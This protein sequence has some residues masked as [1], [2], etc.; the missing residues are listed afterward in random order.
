MAH[1]GGAGVS[2]FTTYTTIPKPAVCWFVCWHVHRGTCWYAVPRRR[3][4][5][6]RPEF[7][8]CRGRHGSGRG[9]GL[10]ASSPR[11]VSG[12]LQRA[13]VGPVDYGGSVAVRRGSRLSPGFAQTRMRERHEETL[14]TRCVA[15]CEFGDVAGWWSGPRPGTEYHG[16]PRLFRVLAQDFR[17]APTRG[18]C[19]DTHLARI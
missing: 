12:K 3:G 10:A 13:S 7:S 18:S 15:G 2:R 4:T 8:S 19:G 16:G 14:A 1:P 9:L 17:L 11:L 5:T 6:S